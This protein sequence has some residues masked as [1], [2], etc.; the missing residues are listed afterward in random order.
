M[1]QRKDG[2]SLVF[3]MRRNEARASLPEAAQPRKP[4]SHLL[5]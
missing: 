3:L 4:E 2:K 5:Q 1:L